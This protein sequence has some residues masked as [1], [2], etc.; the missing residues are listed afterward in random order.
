MLLKPLVLDLPKTLQTELASVWALVTR[1]SVD[2]LGLAV[3][4]P[5]WC[6]VK[7]VALDNRLVGQLPM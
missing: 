6:L 1:H 4:R 2:R 5:I 3:D 7:T